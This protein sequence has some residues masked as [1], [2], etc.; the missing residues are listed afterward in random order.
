MDEATDMI[1]SVITCIEWKAMIHG[2]AKPVAARTSSQRAR[3]R[4]LE[5][6]VI[7]F[8]PGGGRR[9]GYRMHGVVEAATVTP[10]LD[11]GLACRMGA[12]EEV[13]RRMIR[14]ITVPPPPCDVSDGA[15]SERAEHGSGQQ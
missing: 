7:R 4:S 10:P 6:A 8:W 12:R 5:K 14:G 2:G 13:R 1:S 3:S 11:P 9:V 15:C